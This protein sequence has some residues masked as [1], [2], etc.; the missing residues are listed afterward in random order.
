LLE[1]IEKIACFAPG[2]GDACEII[3]AV[4]RAAIA[5]ATGEQA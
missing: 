5:K 4:A 1:A 3:A 2:Y